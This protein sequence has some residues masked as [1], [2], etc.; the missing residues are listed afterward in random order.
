MA[1]DD[2]SEAGEKDSETVKA[3]RKVLQVLNKDCFV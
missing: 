1:P 3:F 2:D